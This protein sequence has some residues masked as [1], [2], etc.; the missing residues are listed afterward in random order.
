MAAFDFPN[1]PSVNDQYTANG[2]TFKWNGTIWQRIS[3]SSGAQGTTGS[4]GPTGAQGAAAGLTISTSA[5]GS[6][7]AGDMWWDS[8]AGLF[9]T[10]YNDGNSSQWV[11]INQGPKGAQGATG[12]TGAQGA[13]GP[14]GAQGTAG[15]Q[16]ATGSAGSNASISNN[17]DDRVITGGSG[18]NLN[19][20][21]R[22][23]F[24][25]S[26]ILTAT[27]T[28]TGNGMGGIRAATANASGN[29]GYGF[30]TNSANRFAVT[31]IGSEG[32]E[33]LRIYDDNNN[34]ERLRIASTGQVLIGTTTPSG[35]SNRLLTVAAADGDS[36]IE[37]R[38]ATDHAGQISFTDGSAGDATNYRGYIQYNHDGDYMRFGTSSTE[39]IRID[40]IG[41]LLVNRTSTYASSSERLSI[42]GMTSIQGSSTSA[43]NLYIFNTDTTGSG[44]VQPYLFLHDGSGIR[45]GLGLQ[46]S[47]SNFIINGQSAIQF[48]TGS[49][50]VGGTERLR[51]NSSGQIQK[52]QDP[53]NRTSLKTYSG[54]GLWFDHYQL[55]VGSTYRRYADIAAVGDGSWG[56]ILRFHT[57]PDGGSATERLRI[58]SS[59]FVTNTY[60]PVKTAQ[61]TVVTDTSNDRFVITLPST[62]RMFRIT[63]SFNFD[64]SGTG[65]IW[66]DF[67]DWSDSHSASLE[68]FAN[69]WRDAAGGPQY[70]DNISGRYFRVATPF[71]YASFEVTYDVLITTVAFNGGGRPG[72]HGHIRWTWNGIGNA[73]TVFSYQDTNATGTDRLNTFAWDIDGV[74]GSSGTGRHHYIIEEYPLT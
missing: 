70:E 15:A 74:T 61:N 12:P 59:G 22:L 58:D 30:M 68:G 44:T 16:G 51:I 45:G 25:S 8:D 38:T 19:G 62:S 3:A 18:T 52:R 11:E 28:G 50:G 60:K 41:R 17:A 24:N 29:A 10:Y 27:E 72:I 35:Y 53:V 64:G 14:T 7:S 57:M 31:L 4:T 54:E 63:G 46:Y 47:T 65:T 71:D 48:R 21:Q 56:G 73:L 13:T 37:L 42:N 49:S 6:P 32:S 33:S 39:R 34:A 43:A 2:V 66:G 5:P 69:V 20:E 40:S 9:L 36:S 1:S 23:T 55:Q 26:N 67:G